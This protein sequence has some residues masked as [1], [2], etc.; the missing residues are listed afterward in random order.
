MADKDFS[1]KPQSGRNAVLNSTV[2]ERSC[3]LP[4]RFWAYARVPNIEGSTLT[5]KDYL[6]RIKPFD[7]AALNNYYVGCYSPDTAKS[8]LDNPGRTPKNRRRYAP[9]E[10]YGISLG[11][12][13]PKGPGNVLACGKTISCDRASQV[14]RTDD[15]VLCVARRSCRKSRGVR[16]PGVDMEKLQESLRIV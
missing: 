16:L 7:A 8:Y 2:S 10:Y 1:Q 11:C 6:E 9:G 14:K 13:V 4:H 15:S 5:A 12:L 3:Q